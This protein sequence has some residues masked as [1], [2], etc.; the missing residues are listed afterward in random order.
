VNDLLVQNLLL[1]PVIAL[2]VK[3]ASTHLIVPLETQLSQLE[4]NDMLFHLR[5][6]QPR[7]RLVPRKPPLRIAPLK[8]LRVFL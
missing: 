8:K 5:K 7:E 4:K 1:V 3:N 6:A 2:F